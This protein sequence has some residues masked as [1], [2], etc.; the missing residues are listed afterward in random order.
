VDE[1]H[2]VSTEDFENISRFTHLFEQSCKKSGSI[3]IFSIDPRQLLT[4]IDKEKDISGKIEKLGNVTEFKLSERIRYNKEIRFF[5]LQLM[6]K[7]NKP[8]DHIDYDNIS[9][10]YA[11][12]SEE[13]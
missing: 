10:A 12:T 2:R 5:I 6:D 7:R 11:D 3:C 9:L 13:A 8:K 4:T 1:T